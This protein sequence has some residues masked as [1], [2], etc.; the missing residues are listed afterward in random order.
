MNRFVIWA[1]FSHFFIVTIILF[2]SLLY[3]KLKNI[4]ILKFLIWMKLLRLAYSQAI[5][6]MFCNSWRE[7]KKMKARGRLKIIAV[8]LDAAVGLVDAVQLGSGER[9]ISTIL[10]YQSR[11]VWWA[12]KASVETESTSGSRRRCISCTLWQGRTEGDKKT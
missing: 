8:F 5:W 11:M 7:D 4:S 9:D 3:W 10:I 2:M 12:D 1:M 6:V